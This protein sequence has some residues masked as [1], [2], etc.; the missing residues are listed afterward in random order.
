MHHDRPGRTGRPAHDGSAVT[1]GST[2]PPATPALVPVRPQTIAYSMATAFTVLMLWFTA[3]GFLRLDDYQVQA[4]AYLAP[5]LAPEFLLQPWAGHFMPAS[6]ALAQV[7]AKTVPF[8]YVPMILAMTVGMGLFA[9]VMARLSLFVLGDRWRALIPLALALASGA[10]WDSA[11]WWVAALNAIPLLIVIPLATLLHLRWLREGSFARGILAWV[12]VTVGCLFFEKTLAVIAFLAVITVVL[13]GR[14]DATAPRRPSRRQ[15]AYLVGLYA[16]TALVFLG[17]YAYSQTG[18]IASVPDISAAMAFIDSGVLRTFP[19]LTMGGPWWWSDAG[20]AAT[21]LAVSIVA[22]N[23]LLVVALLQS[24]RARRA[25]LLWTFCLAYVVINVLVISS[26]R[27]VWGAQVITAPRYFAEAVLFVIITGS[28]CGAYLTAP[29]SLPGR[30]RAIGTVALVEGIVLGLACTLTGLSTAV[31]S[32]PSRVYAVGAIETL[33]RGDGAILNGLVPGFVMW[34][35]VAPENQTRNMFAP[36]AS[37]DLFP[38]SAERLEFLTWS[39]AITPATLRGP[40]ARLPGEPN[41]PWPVVGATQSAAFDDPLPDYWHTVSFD[42]LAGAPMVVEVGLGDAPPVSVRLRTGLHTAYAF[43]S[44]G[45]DR[46]VI[47]R[48]LDGT[49]LCI[50]RVE[51]GAPEELLP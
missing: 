31:L 23:V 19:P 38:D 39:G 49:G 11:T 20:L 40:K 45:G 24:L 46:V 26:G 28:L 1:A 3:Q 33:A 29:G 14:F 7:F 41:C 8:T 10:I 6:F 4:R 35:L 51:V 48:V 32:N 13:R 30:A 2:P 36:I 47:S 37:P 12:T 50:T 21:P 16:A 43:V 27:A 15:N 25:A 9:F 17:T 44:G 22:A 18:S 42:Y 5:W 34:P